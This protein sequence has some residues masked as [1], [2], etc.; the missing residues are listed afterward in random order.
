[1]ARYK[2]K[3]YYSPKRRAI[4]ARGDK[5]DH[6]TLFNLCGWICHICREPIDRKLRFPHNMA[7]TVEHIVP[8]CLGGTHTWDNVA[9]SHAKCNFAKGDSLSEPNQVMIA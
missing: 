9:A 5:I 4:Y 2:G 7:A 3:N 1:M 6:L 8:L